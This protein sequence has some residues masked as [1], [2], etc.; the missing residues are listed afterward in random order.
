MAVSGGG[1]GDGGGGDGDGGTF[2][3]GGVKASSTGSGLEVAVVTI[4]SSLR[5]E[6]GRVLSINRSTHTQGFSRQG[7]VAAA[8]VDAASRICPAEKMKATPST[9]NL[10]IHIYI[11]TPKP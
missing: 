8:A 10:D 6:L 3:I 7:C 1:G 9:R 5:D 11:H 4:T 2:E